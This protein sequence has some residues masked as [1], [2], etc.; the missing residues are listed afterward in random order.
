LVVTIAILVDIQ[1]YNIAGGALS[2]PAQAWQAKA[3]WPL[4]LKLGD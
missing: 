3:C 2:R 4:F 1:I